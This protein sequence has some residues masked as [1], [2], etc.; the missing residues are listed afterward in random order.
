MNKFL[1]L[2]LFALTMY[3]LLLVI[4]WIVYAWKW[5]QV[6]LVLYNYFTT[7]RNLLRLGRTILFTIRRF[8]ELSASEKQAVALGCICLLYKFWFPIC[9]TW[10]W[11]AELIILFKYIRYVYGTLSS[12]LDTERKVRRLIALLRRLK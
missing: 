9:F 8:Q 7:F 10:E 6:I 3:L 1:K 12:L 4:P 11:S 5:T 2:L